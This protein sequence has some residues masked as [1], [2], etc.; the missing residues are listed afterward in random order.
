MCFSKPK[1][2]NSVQK[3]QMKE[4]EEARKREEERQA[5]IKAGTAKIDSVFGTFDDSFYD[6]RKGEYLD[7]YQPQLDD[8][9]KKAQDELTF[10]FARNGTLNSSM[11]AD[12]QAELASK[13]DVEKAGILSQADSAI[14]EMRSRNNNEKS[15]LVAQ[16]Q[17]TGDADR[18]SNEALGRTQ[19]L[20]NERP[21]YNSLGD[22][23]GGVAS[24]IGNYRA[25]QQQGQVYNTYFGSSRNPRQATTTTVR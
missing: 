8:Q 21:S 7:F 22:I 15:A 19:Q 12:K 6:A 17:A 24:A 10:A 25:G 2:D 14:G 4:A 1:V 20:F 13:Y 18:V 23:F 9:F 5:R 11:A 3:Q 16:L